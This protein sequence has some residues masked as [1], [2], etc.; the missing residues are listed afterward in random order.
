MTA[1]TPPREPKTA[2]SL[3]DAS[4]SCISLAPVTPRCRLAISSATSGE[5]SMPSMCAMRALFLALLRASAVSWRMEESRL[6]LSS[7]W[8][9]RRATLRYDGPVLRHCRARVLREN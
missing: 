3:I 6:R 1:A 8:G 9:R 4:G 7:H 2:N 5:P